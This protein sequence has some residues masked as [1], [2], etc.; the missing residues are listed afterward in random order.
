MLFAVFAPFS[1]SLCMLMTAEDEDNLLQGFNSNRQS[2]G[3]APLVKNG[4]ADCLANE[5]A[6]AMEDQTCTTF[7]TGAKVVPASQTQIPDYQKFL[8]KCNIDPNTT[9][10]GVILPVC[11]PDLVP[12]LLLTNYTHTSY[13]KYLNNSKFTGAGL[14]SE[15]DWMVVVLTTGTPT[16]S[17]SAAAATLFANVACLFSL[18]LGL[19][20]FFLI[21]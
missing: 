6:D 3:L 5:I 16:G 18:V 1:N 14:G 12:T 20:V 17:F 8:K 15:D 11:V 19:S 2:Q 10:D 7:A 9:S 4:K 13:S 21:G